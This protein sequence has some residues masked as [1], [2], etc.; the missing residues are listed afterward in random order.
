MKSLIV[1]FHDLHPG[2]QDAC[3]KFIGQL[4]RIGIPRIS[5]LVVPRWH[6]AAPCTQNPAFV[7]WLLAQVAEGHEVCL[8]GYFHQVDR[9]RGG[10][11][12]RLIGRGY[13]QSE[14]EFFQIGRAEADAKIRAGL[15][16]LTAA[17]MPI[18]GFTPPAWL[19][20]EAGRQALIAADL[21]YSTSW[22]K[23]ELFSADRVMPAPTVVYSCRAGWRRVLSL[24]WAPLWYRVNRNAEWLRL[25]VHPGDLKYPAI[26]RSVLGIAAD[27][28]A[29]GRRPITY[30]ECLPPATA[31]VHPAEEI[32]L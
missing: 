24:V 20:S 10:P 7:A 13:T 2:S 31:S 12:A 14:G 16:L 4:A 18:Y 17:G 19:L 25:A 6:G 3:A 11:V 21:H 1:S 26:E 8:H 15:S 22:G 27:A 23:V 30:R 29:T 32:P 9:V 5:L 28:V